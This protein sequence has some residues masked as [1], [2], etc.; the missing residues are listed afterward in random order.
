M[1]KDRRKNTMLTLKDSIIEKLEQLPEP[2]LREVLD[3]VEFISARALV[4]EEPL[5][6]VAGILSGSALSAEQIEQE[7]YGDGPESP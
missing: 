2:A 5:L 1:R 6:A 3:F 4:Q 7:L